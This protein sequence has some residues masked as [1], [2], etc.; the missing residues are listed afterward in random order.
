MPIGLPQNFLN[1]KQSAR[2]ENG[3]QATELLI[4]LMCDILKLSFI[5]QN[6]ILHHNITKGAFHTQFHQAKKKKETVF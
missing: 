2:L 4:Q 5:R 3:K 6:D 1:M